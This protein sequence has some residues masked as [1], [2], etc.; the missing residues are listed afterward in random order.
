MQETEEN[1]LKEKINSQQ[2]FFENVITELDMQIAN[3]K[4]EKDTIKIPNM[5]RLH[6]ISSC[7]S[8]LINYDAE[9]D[10]S[11]SYTSLGI[12]KAN[13]QINFEREFIFESTSVEYLDGLLYSPIK[14]KLEYCRILC[15]NLKEKHKKIN[16]K[17]VILNP[18]VC[19]DFNQITAK[20]FVNKSKNEFTIKIL[21]SKKDFKFRVKS[22][23]IMDAF[24]AY[25]NYYIS[26]SKGARENLMGVSLRKN[27]YKVNIH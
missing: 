23:G 9:A 3:E 4:N 17:E 7:F 21:G 20:T 19:L 5:S 8:S 13:Y 2:N 6:K 11:Y 10:I 25:L 16:D 15:S 14:L 18:L 22:R 1:A 27:F 12:I 26:I 24:L